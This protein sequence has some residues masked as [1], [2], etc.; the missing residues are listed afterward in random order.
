AESN[1]F[2]LCRGVAK[3]MKAPEI[4]FVLFNP[5]CGLGCG[6]AL[7][8]G[9]FGALHLKDLPTTRFNPYG[10]K[11]PHSGFLHE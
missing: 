11:F 6:D 8:T 4:F 7:F 2:E 1:L 10:V 3:D 5:Q 9:L